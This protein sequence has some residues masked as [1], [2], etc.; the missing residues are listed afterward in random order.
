MTMDAPSLQYA[1]R[2]PGKLLVTGS[3]N[4][5]RGGHLVRWAHRRSACSSAQCLH[6]EHRVHVQGASAGARTR[7]KVV[8]KVGHGEER[9]AGVEKVNCAS[10]AG[11]CIV[12]DTI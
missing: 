5:A 8:Q 4:P 9:P 12:S 3:T 1:Y 2:L 7:D 11:A 6:A 10:P